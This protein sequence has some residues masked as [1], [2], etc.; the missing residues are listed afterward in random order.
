MSQFLAGP[1]PGTVDPFSLGQLATQT[2]QGMTAMGNRYQQLGVQQPGGS[3]QAVAK[4]G[5]NMPS[6]GPSTPEKM[7]LGA[8]PSLTGGIPGMAGATLGQ[9]QTNAM[10][11]PTG[12]GGKTGAD[13]FG[14]IFG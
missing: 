9:M 3:P 8:A 14:N 2:Q 1:A 5:G 4:A 6:A 11:S 12:S 13:I 10:T 7:D